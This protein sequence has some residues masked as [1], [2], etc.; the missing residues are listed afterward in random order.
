MWV[1]GTMLYV[2]LLVSLVV[3]EAAHAVTALWGGD[4]TAYFGGQVTLNPIPHIQREPF[5]TVLLP[6]GLLVMSG[7]TMT[8]GYAHAPI[9]PI[10]AYHNPR[11]AAFMSAAGPL[12]NFVLV[13]LAVLVLKCLV[14]AGWVE[15]TRGNSFYEIFRPTDL[16]TTGPLKAV[17]K[18]CATFIYLNLLLGILNLIPIPPLDGAGVVGGLFPRSAGQFY[19]RL[20]G[21]PMFGLMGMIAVFFL[22]FEYGHKILIPAF[23]FAVAIVK[24]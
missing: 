17:C 5:G 18:I 12:S 9:D 24:G 16:S 7:G 10:W 19:D 14:L 21:Q 13:L 1:D 3:H 11:K 23:N 6:V 20:R 2:V 4:R 22:F 8:M 15:V